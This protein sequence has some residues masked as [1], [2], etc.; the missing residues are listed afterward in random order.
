MCCFSVSG[1][2]SSKFVLIM[3]ICLK[4]PS[5]EPDGPSSKPMV[6]RGS[7]SSLFISRSQVSSPIPTHEN[8]AGKGCNT[9]SYLIESAP[10]YI[11]R[12]SLSFRITVD[13]TAIAARL[14][15]WYVRLRC[16]YFETA[17]CD[18]LPTRELSSQDLKNILGVS[19]RRLLRNAPL[20]P[21]SVDLRQCLT[22]MVKG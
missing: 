11:F 22:P 21:R 7:Q 17:L 16:A 19:R 9:P 5:A 3:P 20:L 4:C 15:P 12:S 18:T 10:T 8:S 1:K 2:C 14:S 13:K 6:L